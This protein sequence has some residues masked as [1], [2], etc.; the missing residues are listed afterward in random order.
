MFLEDDEGI[1]NDF[2]EA[3]SLLSVEYT[4]ECAKCLGPDVSFRL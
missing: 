1:Q 2:T 4:R 3:V